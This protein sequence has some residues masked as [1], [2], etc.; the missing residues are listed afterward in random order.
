LA[1]FRSVQWP[2]STI[3]V[4][5]SCLGHFPYSERFGEATSAQATIPRQV[6][7]SALHLHRLHDLLLDVVSSH[8]ALEEGSASA[9]KT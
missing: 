5:K 2:K 7:T 4:L 1:I 8:R 6:V 9:R 3:S